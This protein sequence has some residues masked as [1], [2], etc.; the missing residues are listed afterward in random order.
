MRYWKL[1][2]DLNFDNDFQVEGQGFI[3]NLN[4][5][6]YF[7]A[8]GQGVIHNLNFDNDFQAG[9]Q[10]FIQEPYFCGPRLGFPSVL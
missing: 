4:F 5:E 3:Q 6:N 2:V 1:R 8:E 9:G 10:G 7:Q